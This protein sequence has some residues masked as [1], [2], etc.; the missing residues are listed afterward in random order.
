MRSQPFQNQF[1]TSTMSDS[2]SCSR[3][4]IEGRMWGEMAGVEQKLREKERAP[5]IAA[6]PTALFNISYLPT[7]R[8]WTVINAAL[9]VVT[10]ATTMV[11]ARVP[12]QHRRQTIR[13][14][15]CKLAARKHRPPAQINF[16]Q[17][18]LNLTSRDDFFFGD[19]ASISILQRVRSLVVASLGPCQHVEEPLQGY[20]AH[21][22]STAASW[23]DEVQAPVK[24]S[25]DEAESLL[26][27]TMRAMGKILGVHCDTNI[28]QEVRDW[29][30]QE[31]VDDDPYNAM[32]W[33]ILAVGAQSSPNDRD[34]VAEAYFR[35]GSSI[36]TASKHGSREHVKYMT[37]VGP[38]PHCTIG[39]RDG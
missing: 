28:A 2:K 13:A 11:T 3:A 19:T 22:R 38:S 6:H 25:Q 29:P 8:L 16:Q 23:G 32:F 36:L 12:E 4:L 1:E 7:T 15:T 10:H 9:Y 27:W 14:S 21:F 26:S 31:D 35:R 17:P 20:L 5:P 18:L 30:S 39:G 34:K 37:L 33:I 24:P